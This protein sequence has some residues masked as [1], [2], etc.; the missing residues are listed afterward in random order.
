MK[1]TMRLAIIGRLL[2][3]ICFTFFS[4]PSMANSDEDLSDL[5][6]IKELW[7]KSGQLIEQFTEESAKAL[8]QAIGRGEAI[9]RIV[10]Q[11]Y[12]QN[13]SVDEIYTA[14]L[15]GK[16]FQPEFGNESRRRLANAVDSFTKRRLILLFRQSDPN[17]VGQILSP[18]LD[19]KGDAEKLTPHQSGEGA[20]PKRV[21]DIA[22]NTIR[23]AKD[24]PDAPLLTGFDS[25]SE[26]DAKIVELVKALNA[27]VSAKKREEP[28]T[29]AQ[30]HSN[31]GNSIATSPSHDARDTSIDSD[32]NANHEHNIRYFIWLIVIVIFSACFWFWFRKR[33]K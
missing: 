32:Q 21:C 9:K 13:L 17:V 26:R 30:S 28:K 4:L 12:N 7:I 18:F 23:E 19:D 8:Q 29:K 24:G 11:V 3:I 15:L 10:G 5:K 2:R 6:T 25:V 27:E 22:Y 31:Q 16:H 20:S 1:A 33:E 14:R